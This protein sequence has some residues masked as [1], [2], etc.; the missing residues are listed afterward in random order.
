M[1]VAKLTRSL[2]G[3][4][5]GVDVIGRLSPLTWGHLAAF[6]THLA[7]DAGFT[8]VVRSGGQ[9]GALSSRSSGR[10]MM[11]GNDASQSYERSDG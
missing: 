8:E 11:P 10:S 1:P 7:H 4:Q 6:V 9:S 5:V 3:N 2:V